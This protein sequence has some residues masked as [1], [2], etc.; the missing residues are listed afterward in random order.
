MYSVDVIILSIVLGYVVFHNTY[1]ITEVLNEN[2]LWNR[3]LYL[4]YI[5][6]YVKV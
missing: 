5:I 4:L 2:I 3:Y 1:D 6:R